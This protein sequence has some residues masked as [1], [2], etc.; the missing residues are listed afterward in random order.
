MR[1]TGREAGTRPVVGDES[2]DLTPEEREKL[3]QAVAEADEEEVRL[4]EEQEAKLAELEAE[5]ENEKEARKLAGATEEE[6][7]RAME[8]LQKQHDAKRKVNFLF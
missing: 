8:L 2:D 5:M 7:Q 4:E 6:I 3:A 1:S